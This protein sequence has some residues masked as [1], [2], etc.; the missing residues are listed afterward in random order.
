MSAFGKQAH[1]S[2]EAVEKRRRTRCQRLLRAHESR[3]VRFEEGVGQ[4]R[5]HS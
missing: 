3:M 4:R 2:D 5:A 1:V